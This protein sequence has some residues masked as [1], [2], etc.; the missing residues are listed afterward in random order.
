MLAEGAD[1]LYLIDQHRAHER[2]IYE[3]LLRQLAERA[4]EPEQELIEPLVLELG[5]LQAALLD[6]RLPELA[7]LGISL[8]ELRRAQLP[9]ARDSRPSASTKICATRCPTSSTN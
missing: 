5:P 7:E 8:R 9:G 1:G 2:I 3:R 4:A 6:D